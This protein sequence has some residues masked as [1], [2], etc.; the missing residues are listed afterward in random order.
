MQDDRGRMDVNK[1]ACERQNAMHRS[2][3]I[4]LDSPFTGVQFPSPSKTQVAPP[5]N[6]SKTSAKQ[7]NQSARCQVVDCVNECGKEYEKN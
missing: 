4:M 5:F 6:A 3:I 2:F 1:Y 7:E